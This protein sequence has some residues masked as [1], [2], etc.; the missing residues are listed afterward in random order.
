M[1]GTQHRRRRL[2]AIS[3]TRIKDLERHVKCLE[4]EVKHLRKVVEH[5][6]T[7]QH[8]LWAG[9]RKDNVLKM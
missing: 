2:E 3:A 7:L 9:S 4:A 5:L 8:E 1:N 6:Q